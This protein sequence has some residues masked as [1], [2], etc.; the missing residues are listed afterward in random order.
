MHCAGRAS[1]DALAVPLTAA[2]VKNWYFSKGAK[3]Q[4]YGQRATCRRKGTPRSISISRQ[5]LVSHAAMRARGAQLQF[6]RCRSTDQ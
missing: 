2:F 1:D 5:C 6:C 4:V 3:F